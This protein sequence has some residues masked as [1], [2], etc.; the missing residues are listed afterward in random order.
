[1]SKK[2]KDL[3]KKYTE[4]IE[5]IFD[6]FDEY[7]DEEK[8][9]VETSLKELQSLN[10]ILEK[11]DKKAKSKNIWEIIAEFWNNATGKK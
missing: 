4:V 6:H 8:K 10:V 9:Q 7:T 5:D 3:K 2:S 1:M 11:Y